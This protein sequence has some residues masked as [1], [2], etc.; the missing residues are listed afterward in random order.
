M[1]VLFVTNMYPI[2]DYSYYGIHVKEQIISIEREHK[3]NSKVIFINGRRSKLNYLY[4]VFKIYYFL[5]RRKVDII[6]VHYGLSGLFL[7]FNPFL[8]IPVVLT[9]HG[10]DVNTDNV[11]VRLVV[12]LVIRRCRKIIVMNTGMLNQVKH[13]TESVETIP[14]GVDLNLFKPMKRE[15]HSHVIVGFCGNPERP[16]KNYKLFRDVIARMSDLGYNVEVVVFHNMT[17]EEVVQK[18]NYIDLLLLTSFNEGSPQL[19]KEA[20]AC[21][22]CVI[23]VPVGDVSFILEGLANCRVAKDYQADSLTKLICEIL[24]KGSSS[25]VE[26]REKLRTMGLDQ[27]SV[28]TKIYNTYVNLLRC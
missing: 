1:E 22:T 23:S 25:G 15:S 2:I 11:L 9:L 17:R 24:N 27:V 8:K 6:H 14:C 13:L 5:F 28:A 7:F 3:I 26:G 19:V 18:L 4:S 20:L 12:N 10:S 16:E 21:N